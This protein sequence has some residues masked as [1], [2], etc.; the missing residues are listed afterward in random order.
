MKVTRETESG[1]ITF[2]ASQSM[3]R[4]GN[5]CT[6]FLFDFGDGT[7]PIVVSSSS[8]TRQ[9]LQIGLYK[10]SVT[11][12]DKYGETNA[13]FAMYKVNKASPTQTSNIMNVLFK[14]IESLENQKRVLSINN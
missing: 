3:D 6:C 14:Q 7:S 1:W 12:M 2:D 5:Q 4:D 9:Y 11:V 10:I 13:T 8:V